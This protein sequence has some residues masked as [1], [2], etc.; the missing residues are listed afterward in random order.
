MRDRERTIGNG[1]TNTGENKE[2]SW[3]EL[4]KVSFQRDQFKGFF[5][6]T[7]VKTGHSWSCEESREGKI[8]K[9]SCQYEA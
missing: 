3:D 2:Q 7:K 1:G 5:N 8:M 4:G 6:G 9:I